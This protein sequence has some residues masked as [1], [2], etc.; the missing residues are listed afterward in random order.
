MARPLWA[1]IPHLY[2]APGLP[3]SQG[4]VQDNADVAKAKHPSSAAM[5]VIV[6]QE[7][8]KARLCFTFVESL[9][10]R[11]VPALLAAPPS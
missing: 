7:G 4:A 5:S 2:T 8:V 3:A 6:S 9:H 1:S 10:G 11:T